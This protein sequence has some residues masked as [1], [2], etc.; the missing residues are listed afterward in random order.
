MS[1]ALEGSRN[2]L[3]RALIEIGGVAGFLL[4]AVS[5]FDWLQDSLALG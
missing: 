4:L 2:R 1:K 5:F 3:R